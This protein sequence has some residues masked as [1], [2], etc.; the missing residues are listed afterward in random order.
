M[1]GS[2]PAPRAL[3][4]PGSVSSVVTAMAGQVVLP[5]LGSSPVWLEGEQNRPPAV[6]ICAP[7]VPSRKLCTLAQRRG[8]WWVGACCWL[9]WLSTRVVGGP[10]GGP[11]GHPTARLQRG[12]WGHA[13]A[14]SIFPD[15]NPFNIHQARLPH[16]GAL[17]DTCT[18]S[19]CVTDQQRDVGSVF[20]S[21]A[22]VSSSVRWG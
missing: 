21:R 10:G 16:L 20:I 4:A 6:H 9:S 19:H 5:V 7:C 18:W 11:A 15:K 14:A 2:T 13:A 22:S 17:L 8:P 12:G 1:W 3:S